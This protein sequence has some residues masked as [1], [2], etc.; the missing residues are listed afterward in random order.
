MTRPAAATPPSIDRRSTGEAG[1]GAL[2]WENCEVQSLQDVRSVGPRQGARAKP[3]GVGRGVWRLGLAAFVLVLGIGA[4]SWLEP[5]PPVPATAYTLQAGEP[6]AAARVDVRFDASD[7]SFVDAEPLDAD[8]IV[9]AHVVSPGLVRIAW[10]S[11]VEADGALVRLRFAGATSDVSTQ[12]VQPYRSDGT[13]VS[14]GTVALI[15]VD[16]TDPASTVDATDAESPVEP[17]AHVGDHLPTLEAT[18][19]AYPLGDM[20]R[21]G[22]VDVLDALA[23]L[24]VVEGATPDDYGIYHSDLDGDAET[25]MSDVLRALDKAVNPEL[26]ALPVVKPSY[27]TFLQI[28]EGV[29]LLVGNG[30]NEPFPW[31][32]L[33]L[34]T[35]VDAEL[36]TEVADQAA[37][38]ELSIRPSERRGW[39]PGDLAV[40][41]GTEDEPEV[42]V[43]SL[44]LLVAGQSN[45]SG[46]GLPVAHGPD[47]IAQARMFGNDYLWKVAEEPLDDPTNQV[48]ECSCEDVNAR[49]SFGTALGRHLWDTTGNYSYLIPAAHGATSTSDWIPESD[50]EDRTT[51][52]GSSVFRARVSAALSGFGTQE[53]RNPVVDG[54]AG[55]EGGPVNALVWYQGE[56]DANVSSRRAAYLANT[57]DIMDAYVDELDVPVVYVQLAANSDEQENVE[58]TDIAEKQRRL[59]TG[60]GDVAEARDR[61][62]MVVANDLPLSDKIH[63][64]AFA[65]EMLAERIGLAVREHVLGEQVDGT[66]P[67]LVEVSYEGPT[68]WIDLDMEVT[69][70]GDDYASYFTVFDGPPSGSLD[71]V[72]NYGDNAVDVVDA[73]RDP[74]EATRI[75][76]QLARTTTLAPNVRYAP[77]PNRSFAM[78]SWDEVVTT[79]VRSAESGLPLPT[80]GP[81]PATPR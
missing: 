58:Q 37:A 32:D 4:C 59:E 16:E 62:F 14:S 50:E 31:I 20:N 51:L 66:G 27:V 43:G 44:V 75:V 30:G 69:D 45:A 46:R 24:D 41:T 53:L 78:E 15:A 39:L 65:Q 28:L 26:P 48:D 64:S 60:S 5:P 40:D 8:V 56:S 49:Y 17:S 6:V 9:R 34:P 33:E 38:F 3:D 42:R 18:F 74:N 1:T 81:L 72:E 19:A 47:P 7:A 29:P 36:V 70:A 35:G 12:V 80:L 61:F 54:P 55:S 22:K 25:A 11:T 52:F 63:L 77:P 23:V 68:V 79:V 13:R 71:D 73:Y 10:V 57:N 76:L 2:D 67:R 21:S